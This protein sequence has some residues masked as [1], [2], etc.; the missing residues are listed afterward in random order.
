M[1]RK[2][3]QERERKK[4]TENPGGRWSASHGERPQ[5]GTSGQPACGLGRSACG[6]GIDGPDD[7]HE[8]LEMSWACKVFATGRRVG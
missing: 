6:F 7:L 4:I 1:M 5:P 8:H 3:S 2:V